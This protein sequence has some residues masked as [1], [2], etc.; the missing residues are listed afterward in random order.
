MNGLMK[1]INEAQNSGKEKVIHIFRDE[2]G[3]V[4]STEKVYD[5]IKDDD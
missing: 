3:E 4:K 2:N 5:I 1:L